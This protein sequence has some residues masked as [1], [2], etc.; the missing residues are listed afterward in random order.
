MSQAIQRFFPPETRLTRPAGGFVLWVQLPD[1]IDSLK[2]YMQ[3][4]NAGIA[5]TPGYLFSATEQYRNFV[6]LNAANWSD[7]AE[8]AI[9]RLGQLTAELA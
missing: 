6:R 5:I 9:E 1:S 7:K 8:R 2:L 3:A 4:L